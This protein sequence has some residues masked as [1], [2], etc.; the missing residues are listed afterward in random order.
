MRLVRRISQVL[1]FVFFLYLFFTTTYPLESKIPPDLFLRSSPLVA[2]GTIISS[3]GFIVALVPAL[4]IGLLTI[5]LGRFFCGWM[6]PLG[7]II[8]V[9]DRIFKAPK[10][11][12]KQRA[13]VKFR[14]WKFVILIIVL[15]SALFSTQLIWIFDPIALLTRTIATSIFPIFAFLIDSALSTLMGIS[16]LES[17]VYDLYDRLHVSVLPLEPHYFQNGILFLA[18]FLGMLLLGKISPRFW[19]RNLCPLGALLGLFSK[20]RI[21]RRVVANSC[22]HCGRCQR[23]CKMNAIEDDYS[24]NSTI[25]CIECLNCVAECPPESITYKIGLQGKTAQVDLSRRQFVTATVAG[26]TAVGVFKTGYRNRE[27]NEKALRP[28]GALEEA[29]FLD[30]CIRCHA[31]TKICSTTGGCL[32]PALLETGWE[33]LWTPI[34]IPRAGFCEYNCNLCGQV[35]PTSA[36]KNLPLPDKQKMKMGTAAFDKNRCIPWYR[37]E[38]CLVCEEHCPVSEKAIQFEEKEV[39]RPNGEKTVVKFPYVIESRCVGCGICVSKCP[40]RGSAGIFINN[41]GETRTV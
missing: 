4:F 27:T 24:E 15:G 14:S 33:G 21:T 5:P 18:L 6:C 2:L 8:D 7:T 10:S 37:F 38:N 19:C 22:T 23:E 11:R 1:F 9:G 28:P 31:C 35:C 29:A 40:L 25:E 13:S 3:R 20:Y 41:S 36:I 34:S 16:W 39:T 30:R 12:P 26:V 32:Q 17:P